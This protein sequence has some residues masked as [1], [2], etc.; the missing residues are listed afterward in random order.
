MGD[1][2]TYFINFTLLDNFTQRYNAIKGKL[3][4]WEDSPI[5]ADLQVRS[6]AIAKVNAVG[7]AAQQAG[8]ATTQSMGAAGSSVNTLAQRTTGL[9]GTLSSVGAK[10]QGVF[11]ALKD[12]TSQLSDSVGTLAGSFAAMAAGAGV[13]G[14][15]WLDKAKDELADMQA[16]AK[17]ESNKKDKLSGEQVKAFTESYND[18][19]WTREN[20][21]L[22]IV[23]TVDLWGGKKVAGKQLDISSQAA[24]VYFKS[25]E[26]LDES[27]VGASE[28]ARMAVRQGEL[29]LYEMASFAAAVGV[30]A[31][32][33]ALKT[34][35][36]RQKLLSKQAESMTSERM[37]EETAKRPWVVAENN[38]R[39]LK[40][41]IGSA[42]GGPMM[43]VTGLAAKFIGILSK[44][45]GLPG[46]IG[47]LAIL[48]AMGGAFGILIST[49]TP[50]YALMVKFGVI[51]RVQIALTWA[52]VVA[53][54]ALATMYGILTGS[55]TLTTVATW[56]LN[57]AMAVLDALN[58]FTYIILAGAVLVG[59]LGYL[60]Y[61][62]GVLGAI[63]KTLSQIR[64][65]KIFDD[66]MKGDFT[67]AWKKL[68]QDLSKIWENLPKLTIGMIIQGLF[69]GLKL[70][71]QFSG[72]GVLA[73]IL[74]YIYNKIG[75]LFGITDVVGKATNYV[76]NMIVLG[77]TKLWETI[78]AL[79][80]WLMH[81]IPGGD[82][83]LA[84]TAWEKEQAKYG[85]KWVEGVN[86]AA[87]YYV[88]TKGDTTGMDYSQRNGFNAGIAT[89][90]PGGGVVANVP[91]SVL[92]A[93][94]KYDSK[95]TFMG[96]LEA[97]LK[98]AISTLA[99][100]I[101]KIPLFQTLSTV[102]GTLSTAIDN[103]IKG[104]GNWFGFGGTPQTTTATFQDPND[105]DI[106]YDFTPSAGSSAAAPAGDVVIVDTLNGTQSPGDWN[107]LSQ[108]V[109]L[110]LLA[111]AKKRKLPAYA[112]GAT[113]ARG[114]IFS[115]NVHAPEEL[116]P[117]ATAQRG[118]G[119]IAKAMDTLDR[120]MSGR[121]SGFAA[122]AGSEIHI[123]MPSQ[124][125]SG[126]KISSDV[127]FIQLLDRANKKAVNDAVAAVK[128]QLGQRRT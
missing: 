52:W 101:M 109:Q 67:G 35:K 61:K 17:F 117:Q 99:A 89:T 46:L 73:T 79:Y 59:I 102:L 55:I 56:L 95:L 14:L 113:F 30:G 60:A 86:G 2:K 18:S 11:S 125:F 106:S 45:P 114:G 4:L 54:G 37:D 116:I 91:Q 5:V 12:T 16:Y 115:G 53:K 15:S 47:L 90:T 105:P 127:D 118:P 31:D 1:T 123:H 120:A 100:E 94:A 65:G 32:D 75:E 98:A 63:W 111:N 20:A 80:N 9:G 81:A 88:S 23:N 50:F 6:D 29:R 66:I 85:M 128:M 8:Q 44:I 110:G 97:K 49:M 93:Q 107:S 62:S 70:A 3:D 24:R 41:A 121:S 76:L 39:N 68:K 7:Q 103:L 22:D 124:D 10:A 48:T 104:I 122:G 28:I 38:I 92:D 108:D 58:P 64:F 25:K 72:I 34:A 42:L 119:P 87:G 33:S 13:A 19:G 112:S 36:G 27:G 26:S 69:S 71:F 96:E 74:T 57:A 51:T 78:K 40:S 43:L 21:M 77:V 82:K 126:M 84:K 83:A